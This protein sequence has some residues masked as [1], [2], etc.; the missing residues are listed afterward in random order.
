MSQRAVS[1][2]DMPAETT[3]PPPCPQKVFFWSMSQM[4]SVRIGSS[5]MIRAAKSFAI[6]KPAEAPT[7]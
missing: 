2:A 3:V 4:Y 7:P 5:P 1:I 6:P